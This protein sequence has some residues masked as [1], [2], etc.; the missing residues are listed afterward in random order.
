M[1]LNEPA[2]QSNINRFLTNLN[3]HLTD[4]I[5]S[6][7]SCEIEVA[8]SFVIP[9]SQ[10][11]R[12]MGRYSD[13]FFMGQWYPQIA[14]FDDIRGWDNIPYFGL[15]EFYNDFNNY[16]VTIKV[17]DGY[18]VWATGECDNLQDVLDKSIIK[19][20]NLAKKSDSN[21]AIV[22]SES[23]STNPF[24]GSIWHFKA[25]HVPDF[26]FAAATNYL[27]EGT[28]VRQNQL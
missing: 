21:V 26:A 24:K 8:W 16:D 18:M 2:N 25:G 22:N 13:D 27:W 23:F 15:Q 10:W 19:N 6:G 14:V 4:S 12:R 17:P 11:A 20:L 5:V 1:L 7:G 9:S 28:S 3:V